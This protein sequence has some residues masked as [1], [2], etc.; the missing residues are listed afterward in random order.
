LRLKFET[1]L[2]G[3]EKVMKKRLLVAAILLVSFVIFTSHPASAQ[4]L[5]TRADDSALPQALATGSGGLQKAIFL[6]ETGAVGNGSIDVW[7]NAFNTD[8]TLGGTTP[9]CLEMRYSGEVKVSGIF[10][11]RM[12]F[13]AL[14]DGVVAQGGAPFFDAPSYNVYTTTAVN[15]WVCG[16]SAGTHTV[17]IQFGPYFAVGT[18]YV[19]NRTLIIEYKQ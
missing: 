16:L 15:W 19:R 18:S 1:P 5:G 7:K 4:E 6:S 2:K 10:P 12:Q 11:L 3:K 14:V 17:Q 9:Q 8:V 13:R